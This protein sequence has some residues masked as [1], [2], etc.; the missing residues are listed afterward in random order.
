MS[1]LIVTTLAAAAALGMICSGCSRMF[2]EGKG[3]GGA[4]GRVSDPTKSQDLSSYASM[5][6][7]DITIAN[8]VNVP[9][10]MPNLIR[11]DLVSVTDRRGLGRGGNPKLRLSG[12]IIHYE[13]GSKLDA[14]VS[15]FQEV[16]LRTRLIDVQSGAIVQE[17]NLIG[18][19]KAST[20]SGVK[21]LSG[22]VGEALDSWLENGGARE[23]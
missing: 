11:S 5:D 17:T 15:P 23:S 7:D 2:A 8:G 4:S 10:E 6:V 14:V 3:M 21:S 19:A 22:G 13:D 20:S 16:V 1:R 9:S 12:E 18:R